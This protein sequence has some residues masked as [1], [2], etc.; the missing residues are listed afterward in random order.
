MQYV[1]YE[2]YPN[3]FSNIT[4]LNNFGLCFE[5]SCSIIT[6]IY[7]HICWQYCVQFGLFYL[8]Q[9]KSIL[10]SIV[11]FIVYTNIVQDIQVVSNIAQ[12]RLC[13]ILCT[14]WILLAYYTYCTYC[15]SYN[16]LY[17]YANIVQYCPILYAT[18]H[19]SGLQM[20]LRSWF[21]TRDHQAAWLSELE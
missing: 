21:G 12:S 17:I 14:T 7:W 20:W 4:M 2:Q 11:L 16:L 13:A 1:Q 15:T 18:L 9:Y 5:L 10:L 8:S 6:S 19:W 3:I